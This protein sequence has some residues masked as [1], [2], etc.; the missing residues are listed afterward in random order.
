ME[1]V[2][3]TQSTGV[4]RGMEHALQAEREKLRKKLQLLEVFS[5][6]ND[7]EE[8][9]N[10]NLVENVQNL[11]NARCNLEEKGKELRQEWERLVQLAKK[12]ETEIILPPI[13]SNWD[14]KLQSLIL[15]N[16]SIPSP[17]RPSD[18]SK[19]TG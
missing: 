18:Q 3:S 14:S 8:L 17:L 19:H 13:Y 1:A 9:P 11:V 15:A 4:K 5:G 16:L 10:D 12:N 2:V 6:P 7:T